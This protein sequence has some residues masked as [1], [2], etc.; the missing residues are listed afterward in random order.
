MLSKER[1]EIKK[2]GEIQRKD[3]EP[4]PSKEVE[5]YLERVE[6]GDVHLTKPVLDDQTGQVLVTA[7]S[8]QQPTI[9]LPLDKEEIV[10]A[11][12]K[13][14]SEAVRWL[15]EWCMRLIKMDPQRVSFKQ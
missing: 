4:R 2:T 13:K 15:A 10:V 7:P 9:V 1:L 6:K 8:A 12:K 14:V 11:L 3:L 5:G